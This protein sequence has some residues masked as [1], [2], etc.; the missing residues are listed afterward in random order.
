MTRP[1]PSSGNRCEFRA[2]AVLARNAQATAEGH[3]L[4]ALAPHCIAHLRPAY[5]CRPGGGPPFRSHDPDVAVYRQ[6]ELNLFFEQ[7]LVADGCDGVWP[8]V[9]LNYGASENLQLH[10]L[11]P[12]AFT[13][14]SGQASGT[15]MPKGSCTPCGQPLCVQN[16]PKGA[17]TQPSAPTDLLP[18]CWP[19]ELAAET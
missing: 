18:I 11:T 15:G 10:L 1:R 3:E 13:V 8:G 12:I 14:P 19:L 16:V 5:E 9:E 7:T 17:S 6:F 4:Q 2:R